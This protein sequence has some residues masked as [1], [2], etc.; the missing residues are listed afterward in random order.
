MNILMI[1]GINQGEKTQEELIKKW[2]GVLNKESPGLLNE[3]PVE[4]PFYGKIL[5]KWTDK[6]LLSQHQK[7]IWQITATQLVLASAQ[8]GSSATDEDIVQQ[9]LESVDNDELN[10][11]NAALDS[12]AKTLDIDETKIQ[13]E[14]K[15][16]QLG[17]QPQ[18]FTSGNVLQPQSFLGDLFWPL[19]RSAI[20]AA[21]LIGRKSPFKGKYLLYL[22]KGLRESYTYLYIKSAQQEVDAIVWGYLQK[23]PQVLIA[24]SLGTVITFKLLR[25]KQEAGDS[26]DIPLLITTGSPLA[27]AL[28]K[29]RIGEPRYKP[30]FVKKW[31]NFYDK[32]DIATEGKGL[33]SQNFA[34]GIDN[35]KVKNETIHAHGISGY[36]PHT[37]DELKAAI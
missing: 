8:P 7:H 34:P 1:H 25:E 12:M 15:S 9:T 23:S 27:V 14:A 5:E 33:T 17:L 29:K 6:R 13:N 21:R 22:I 11:I 37:V 19:R 30:N 16:L 2:T 18:A 28:F 3:I 32:S 36:L 20:A 26:I 10:F 24:H 4:M 35:I 31:A